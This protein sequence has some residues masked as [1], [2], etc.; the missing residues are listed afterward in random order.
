MRL[1]TGMWTCQPHRV[2][3]D[4]LPARWRPPVASA[5]AS[6]WARDRVGYLEVELGAP[7]LGSTYALMVATRNVDPGAGGGFEWGAITSETPRADVRIFPEGGASYYEAILGYWDD[8]V[9][10]IRDADSWMQ[11]LSTWLPVEDDAW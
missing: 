4:A 9:E 6:S 10:A 2:H 11:P 1:Q 8:F 5:A 3:I 7:G